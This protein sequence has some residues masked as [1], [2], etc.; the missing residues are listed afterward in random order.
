MLPSA[1]ASLDSDHEFYNALRA[2]DRAIGGPANALD[3]AITIASPNNAQVIAELY[4]I[5]ARATFALGDFDAEICPS[6]GMIL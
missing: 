1:R 4:D 5:K 2:K 6:T 3:A